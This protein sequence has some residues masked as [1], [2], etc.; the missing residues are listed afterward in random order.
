MNFQM[1]QQIW[2]QNIF[3]FSNIVKYILLHIIFKTNAAHFS[4]I[5]H[6]L[7]ILK[8]EFHFKIMTYRKVILVTC[9]FW[10]YYFFAVRGPAVLGIYFAMKCEINHKMWE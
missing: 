2:E 8:P 6:M 4:V 9:M 7:S 1:F 5:S 3:F 10:E